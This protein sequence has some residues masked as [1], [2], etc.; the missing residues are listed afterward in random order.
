VVVDVRLTPMSRTPG[1]ARKRLA[2]A[3]AAV[4]IE[5]RHEPDLGNPRDNREPFNRGEPAA[6]DRMR[7]RLHSP[8]GERAV[9]ELIRLME[10]GRVCLLCLEGDPATCHRKVVAEEVQRRNPAVQVHDIP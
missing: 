10:S 3:L 7:A 6:W 5:Y 8:A 4:G 1:M 9:D 2:D